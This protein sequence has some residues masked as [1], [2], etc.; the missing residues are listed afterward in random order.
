[1]RPLRQKKVAL[2]APSV[3]APFPPRWIPVEVGD[4][5]NCDLTMNSIGNDPQMVLIQISEIL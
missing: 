2:A 4:L 3:Q 5:P 1:M